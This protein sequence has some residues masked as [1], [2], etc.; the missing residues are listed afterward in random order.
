MPVSTEPRATC[1]TTVDGSSLRRTANER[2]TDTFARQYGCG[3]SGSAHE[4]IDDLEGLVDEPSSVS[5]RP[6]AYI[7]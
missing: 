2:T 3:S 1:S 7:R 5:A 4:R 6:R